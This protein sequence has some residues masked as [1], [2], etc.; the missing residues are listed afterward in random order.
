MSSLFP[1]LFRNLAKYSSISLEFQL[2]IGERTQR[3]RRIAQ[4]EMT[5]LQ[6]RIVTNHA[7]H[8]ANGSNCIGGT[9]GVFPYA[10]PRRAI[11]HFDGASRS[12]LVRLFFRRKL[13]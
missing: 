11:K 13:H 7:L 12:L 10:I 9:L 5:E 3:M 2:Q 6:S 8:L 4:I 1:A